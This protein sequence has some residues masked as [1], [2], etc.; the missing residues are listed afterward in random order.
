MTRAEKNLP[1]GK[2]YR[3]K[4]L[5]P[6]VYYY[7]ELSRLKTFQ[8]N[9]VHARKSLE[10]AER[11]LEELPLRVDKARRSVLSEEIRVRDQFGFIHQTFPNGPPEKRVSQLTKSNS[12]IVARVQKFFKGT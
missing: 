12:E 4:P 1:V 11:E 2:F 8:N 9:L 5:P 10:K 3:P 6:E 7:Q